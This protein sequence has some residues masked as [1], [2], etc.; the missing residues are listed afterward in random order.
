[1]TDRESNGWSPFV[2]PRP[3][4]RDEKKLFFG[5]NYESEKIVSLIFG[6]SL[7]L[8]YAQSGA[9]KTSLFNAKVAP[10]LEQKGLQVLPVARVGIG[11]QTTLTNKDIEN[12][13]G[14]N[15]DTKSSSLE[16]IN[17][18]LLNAFQSILPNLPN[19]EL[20][21]FRSLAEFLKDKFPHPI[22]QRGKQVPQLLIFD[23][24]EEVFSFYSD[25][26]RWLENQK[27]F[28]E[29]LNEALNI[30]PL[31][32]I[33][34]IIREDFL[35]QLDPFAMLVPEK[36]KPRFRLERLRRDAAFDAVKGPLEQAEA[37]I[38]KI[39]IRKLF[40]EGVIDK[41]IDDLVKIRVETFEGRSQDVK[42]E[43]VEPIQLQVVCQ[44]LWEKL[45]ISDADKIK[46]DFLGEVDSALQDFYE[47]S[48]REASKITRIE[49]GT[50]RNWF[51]ERLITASGTRGSVHR[52]FTSTGDIS[53]A[54]VD[55]LENKYIIRKEVRAGAQWYELAHDRLIGPIKDSNNQ[56][57]LP[58]QEK[59]AN[60][61]IKSYDRVLKVDPNNVNIWYDRGLALSKIGRYDEAIQSFDKIL[62]IDERKTRYIE[63][64][65][66]KGLA[67]EKLGRSDDAIQSY[68]KVLEID[69]KNIEALYNKSNVY[70]VLGKYQEAEGKSY[71]QAINSYRE[72]ISGLKKI[73]DIQPAN[74]RA[75]ELLRELFSNYTFEYNDALAIDAKL[76]AVESTPVRKSKFAEE[77][78]KVGK[79][80]KGSQLAFEAKKQIPS[81]QIK[82]QSCVRLLILAS[83]F[84][85]GNSIK[86]NEELVDFLKFYDPLENFKVEEKEWNF[87]GLVKVINNR[88]INPASKRILIDLIDLLR[89]K[90]NREKILSHLLSSVSDSGVQIGHKAYA[91]IK[92]IVPIA[93][94][95]VLVTGIFSF[96]FIEVIN[97]APCTVPDA[98]I[99]NYA[100]GV[101]A[102]IVV[103][104]NTHV[105]YVA[106]SNQRAISAIDCE[107]GEIV[108]QIST[109]G[110]VTD[111]SIDK[112][113]NTLY[114]DTTDANGTIAL[115]IDGGTFGV[116]SMLEKLVNNYIRK[117]IPFSEYKDNND[118]SKVNRSTQNA[119]DFSGNKKHTYLLDSNQ[120]TIYV[121][122]DDHTAYPIPSE[123]T[124]SQD[125]NLSKSHHIAF[126]PDKNIVYLAND[127]KN[128][129]GS[130][131]V[132]DAAN[133]SLLKT[134]TGPI[135]SIGSIA[136]DSKTNKIYVTD[137]YRQTVLVING[138]N[139]KIEKNIPVGVAPIDIFIDDINGMIYIANIGS[140]AV[141]V[142]DGTKDEVVKIIYL[143]ENS[144]V[145][146]SVSADPETKM[147]YVGLTRDGEFG[148]IQMINSTNPRWSDYIQ[149]GPTLSDLVFNSN[150]SKLYITK[151]QNGS[152]SV[153]DANNNQTI[154]DIFLG[155]S[156]YKMVVNLNSNKIY[157]VNGNSD[158]ISVIDG[159]DDNLLKN[160]T[161]PFNAYDIAVNPNLNKIYA[162]GENNK[163]LTI[164]DGTND[165][166]VKNE[167][168]SFSPSAIEFNPK[169]NRLY[170]A[171][172][173]NWSLTSIDGSDDNVTNGKVVNL[174]IPPQS[175][176][177]EPVTNK[178]YVSS[179]VRE[180]TTPGETNVKP[181]SVAFPH[182]T[183][184]QVIDGS[185]D[186][187]LFNNKPL[188]L[189]PKYGDVILAA[190]PNNGDIL[191]VPLSTDTILS[192]NMEQ[193]ERAINDTGGNLLDYKEVRA[194]T[195]PA[196]IAFNVQNGKKDMIYI[197][198]Y[199][200]NAILVD[201]LKRYETQSIC[202]P[203]QRNI[204]L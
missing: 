36:L 12:N 73:V 164:I 67:L 146:T 62:E 100:M 60:E 93:L 175:I 145:L 1:M 158:M 181:T 182:R 156:P 65:N 75:L 121:V 112:K 131:S 179:Y 70:H 68:D 103:N 57:K 152:I 160:I 129:T 168:L 18:Y 102:D 176:T 154:K 61:A 124:T 7:V 165:D 40:D 106:H 81:E 31:L 85:E 133:H 201:E 95:L 191:A 59:K 48:I 44:R 171:N 9:G 20:V 196:E 41:L 74:V 123:S 136:F 183:Q 33:V 110:I 21:R 174:S 120:S 190:D 78:I 99:S 77:L 128:G 185:N 195:D 107:I 170:I 64:L 144:G 92:A 130:I 118:I 125:T 159:K 71:Q 197:V 88:P 79:N 188:K 43:F 153:I 42:G 96:Y 56:W 151:T 8:I 86:G 38:Y 150:T 116:E 54:V 101:P 137:P 193:A 117:V 109:P 94:A 69:E 27:D 58:E 169:T 22:N 66:A 83:Y 10:S 155:E 198:N 39:K 30:D 199:K 163:N 15:N 126:N 90:G 91:K 172:Y 46:Q 200:L 24:L 166:V 17:P 37:S 76:L 13:L 84:L 139:N 178:L 50:I 189:D 149:V 6:H 202:Q 186:K 34:F 14:K 35:A 162:I 80:K 157:V 51:D 134:I 161:L 127:Y 187:V 26:A 49:E 105:V 98:R 132:I 104:N 63:A 16:K 173:N 167:T 113:T 5:R 82:R 97:A 147:V 141:S 25:P 47:D 177:V 135:G 11:S 142:I 115:A 204:C 87:N 28:F 143:P 111:L 4:R 29:Q 89:G 55:I 53:N 140:N 203:H 108:E 148:L 194:G 114:A 122:G 72:A 138:T 32:R 19:S 3:F 23:Q 180:D 2:G 119:F 192:W 45:R 52:S 184:V